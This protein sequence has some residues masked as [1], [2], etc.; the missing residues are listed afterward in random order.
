MKEKETKIT[1]LEEVVIATRLARAKAAGIRNAERL[2][3]LE[4]QSNQQ[5]K[6]DFIPEM[7]DEGRGGR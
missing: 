7:E 6:P 2:Y 4:M 5:A 1:A 3:D